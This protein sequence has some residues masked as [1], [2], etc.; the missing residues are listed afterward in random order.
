[1]AASITVK[2][3]LNHTK[4]TIESFSSDGLEQ[5]YTD[6][7]V[8]TFTSKESYTKNSP[9]YSKTFESITAGLEITPGDLGISLEAFP[10]G[11]Y[12]FTLLFKD[13]FGYVLDTHSVTALILYNSS[14]ILTKDIEDSATE[15]ED[16]KGD[17][18]EKSL[19]TIFRY[20]LELNAG[21][22]NAI[23]LVHNSMEMLDKLKYLQQND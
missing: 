21:F 18:L 5:D 7:V 6:L 9:D 12:R 10:D 8:G 4:I 19:Q 2:N 14:I 20:T 13:P 1:M 17:Y 22:S 15:V 11:I 23:G 16:D 3:N